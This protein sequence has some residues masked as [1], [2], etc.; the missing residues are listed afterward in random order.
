MLKRRSFLKFAV[1]LLATLPGMRW[2]KPTYAQN[3]LQFIVPPTVHHVEETQAYIYYWVPDGL[4]DLELILSQGEQEMRR[5]ALD[6]TRATVLIDALTPA[7]SY[8]FRMVSAGQPQVY[9]NDT[10]WDAVQFRT[11]PFEWPLRFVTVGDSGFGDNITLQLAEHMAAQDVDFLVHL[12]DIVYRMDEYAADPA[13]NFAEKYF[14]PF[15][16]VLQR[17]PHYPTIGNHDRDF[18]TLFEGKSFYHWV[19]PPYNPEDAFEDQRMWYSFTINDVRFLCLNTQVFFTDRGRQ[20][21]NVWLRERLAERD[22]RTNIIFFHVPFRGSSPQHPNDGL[23]P[24]GDWELLF[25]EHAEQIALVMSGHIHLYE[26]LVMGGINYLISGGG[27]YSI[28]E[29]SPTPIVGSQA[30]FSLAHYVLIEVYQDR[31]RLEAFDV[32]NTRI[33]VAEWVI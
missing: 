17:G 4:V 23:A 8:V 12:G 13:R 21:Q 7:T 33:D 3:A 26:H 24:A 1:G 19:F 6:A 27:S 29:S 22:F 31:L 2:L 20:E 25:Q 16:D 14:L 10:P 28:Y 18:A 30:L 11:Q 5:I 15:K 9:Y 32:N